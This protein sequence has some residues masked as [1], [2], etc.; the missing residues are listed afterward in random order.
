MGAY[1]DRRGTEYESVPLPTHEV[2]EAVPL[3]AR[4]VAKR[5][6]AKRAVAPFYDGTDGAT[7]AVQP[8][9]HRRRWSD[10]QWVAYQEYVQVIAADP[11]D[12]APVAGMVIVKHA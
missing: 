11:E 12:A 1:R 3:S 2:T 8:R 7:L 6:A 9:A 5:S 10:A 4:L